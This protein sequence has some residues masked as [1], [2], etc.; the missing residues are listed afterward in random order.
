M[1]RLPNNLHKRITAL[2]K[3][4]FKPEIDWGRIYDTI[5]EMERT[6]NPPNPDD[7]GFDFDD[8]FVRTNGTREEFINAKKELHTKLYG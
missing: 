6:M 4:L 1:M 5:K 7:P 2:E 3:L 8:W